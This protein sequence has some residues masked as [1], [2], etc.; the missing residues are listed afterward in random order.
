MVIWSSFV[1]GPLPI[2]HNSLNWDLNHWA[3][4]RNREIEMWG[5]IENAR[6]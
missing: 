5:R 3:R 4:D 1:F 2:V 6:F